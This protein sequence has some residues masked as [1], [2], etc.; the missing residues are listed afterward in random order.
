VS[1][2]ADLTAEEQV[3]ALRDLL[4]SPGWRLVRAFADH[5]WGPRGYGHRMQEAV[6]ST[7]GGAERAY[8]LADAVQRVH[9]TAAAVNALIAWPSSGCGSS[10]RIRRRSGCSAAYGGRDMASSAYHRRHNTM[11]EKR[12]AYTPKSAPPGFKGAAASI[13]RREGVSDKRADAILA[14]GARKA[15]AKAKKRNPRL[16]KGRGV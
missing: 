10:R 13:E 14:A 8:E 2:V 16:N 11:A 4:A 12:E 9:Q 3:A 5:E 1:D 6:T 7:P 15:S